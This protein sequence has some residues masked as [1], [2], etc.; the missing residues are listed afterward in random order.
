MV[1]Y[2]TSS[3]HYRAVVWSVSPEISIP[4]SELASS[5]RKKGDIGHVTKVPCASIGSSMKQK[6]YLL[7]RAIVRIK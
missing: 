6:H 5:T 3:S 4:G 2:W 7:Y 1:Y